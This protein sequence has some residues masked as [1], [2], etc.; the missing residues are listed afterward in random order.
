MKRILYLLAAMLLIAGCSGNEKASAPLFS[1]ASAPSFNEVLTSRR[2]IRK[3]DASKTISEAEVR[4]LIAAA[5]D[6][7]S[8]ANQ[9]PSKYYVAISPEKLAAVQD[10]VGGNKSRILA[11]PVLIVSTYERGKSGFFRGEQTNE[12]G[13]YWGAY[14]NGLS[15]AYLILVA[16]AMGFDTLI[17]GMRDAN[18]LRTLFHIPAEETVMAV[19]ALGYRA[20]DPTRPVH[21]DL[22]DI[23]KFY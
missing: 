22:D 7:P 20:E 14:D 10:L 15:N 16:R 1:N 13:E 11:A 9:Q 4:T 5:Q 12:L 19:I 18:A 17:M 3:Y 2:S 8:W 23:V 6:A 21:R